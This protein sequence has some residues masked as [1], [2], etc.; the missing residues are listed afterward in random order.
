MLTVTCPSCGKKGTI[1]LNLVGSRIKCK[2]C[3]SSFVV[4]PPPVQTTAGSLDDPFPPLADTAWEGFGQPAGRDEPQP[5]V[6][7]VEGLDETAW[8]GAP[9]PPE[10]AETQAEHP[11]SSSIFSALP[12]PAAARGHAHPG[13]PKEYKILTRDDP[14][15]DGVFDLHRLEE[16]LNQHA[17]QG[18]S[19]RSLVSARAPAGEAN[20]G[21]QLIVLM[22]R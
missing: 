7:L 22:E 18:W 9:I 14:C 10:A 3:R 15:F 5:E 20:G 12:L 13:A 16:A 2:V 4:V 21:P 17:R 19:V 8:A 11:S 1:P 6:I